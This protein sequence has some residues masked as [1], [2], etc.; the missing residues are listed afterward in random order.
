ML[1]F[2]RKYQKFF[3]LFVTIVIVFTFVFFGT[4][5]TIAPAFRE[6]GEEDYVTQMVRFLETEQ[7]MGSR[8]IF[9]ANFLN[10]GV[11]SEDF[12][13]TGMGALIAA[14]SPERFQEEFQERVVKEKE[15]QPYV[16]PAMPSLSAEMIWSIFAPDMAEAFGKLQQGDGGFSER[17]AL[18]LA[19][20]QFPPAFFSQVVR[21]QEQSNPRC[22]PDPRL[23]RED[24]ALF[25]YQTLSDWFGPKYV[26]SVAE[27]I[28]KGAKKAKQLGYKTSKK[29]VMADLLFRS[30][31]TFQAVNGKIPL[32]VQD[33]RGLMQLYLRQIGMTEET[34]LKIWEDVTLFR[35]L[36]HA[37]GD[38]ALID[39]LALSRFYAFAFENATVE[40]YQLPVE[41][42]LKSLAELEEF[43]S[44]LAAVSQKGKV[45]DIPADYAALETILERA[46]ELVGRRYTVQ[47]AQTSKK[48]LEAKVSL[49]ETL[50][51]ECDAAHWAAIA[52]QFPELA[53]KSGTPFE[54][55]EKME[56][57]GK[58]LVDVFARKKIV[59]SHPEWIQEALLGQEME[60]RELFLTTVK[61][62]LF[63]GLTQ[64]KKL[65]AAFEQDKELLSYTEDQ[66]HYF[67]FSLK[68]RGEA[69][70]ILTFKEAQKLGLLAK[71]AEQME[72]KKLAQHVVE[73]CP[74]SFQEIPFA[75]RFATFM[76]THHFNPP[77][78]S[79]EKQ[80]MP[81]KRERTVTRCEKSFIPLD[82][83][84]ALKPGQL[85][86]VKVDEAEGAYLYR[87]VDKKVDRTL[88]LEKL[89]EAEK[90][91][92]QEA[93]AIYFKTLLSDA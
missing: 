67:R 85:S 7:W 33:G 47:F 75:Y 79:L 24:V 5:Q 13:A 81:E 87:C 84:L 61:Q 37:V 71:L 12:L 44:Y 70:E 53:E 45:L 28:I 19:Q 34:A 31:E 27:L 40:L 73:A 49:K 68:E 74:A 32:P 38:A 55:L 42:R 80:F 54:I 88:P 6:K 86:H 91:L 57:K 63:D 51:W 56:A 92:S 59:E 64:P 22:P 15:Y 29:E 18:F 43:E 10:D 78:G 11:V 72:G 1:Q 4:Y 8:R 62:K 69:Q 3:F 89:Q 90:M 36:L 65:A 58:K 41:Y 2:F 52:Q 20:K 25:G 30:Q 93:R 23:A 76:S 46:P 82:E 77:T 50:D 60:E 9:G 26:E 17:K 21:Y 16:H 66:Q 35:R 48:A 39:P 14:A 83:V